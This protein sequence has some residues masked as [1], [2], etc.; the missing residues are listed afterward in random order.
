MTKSLALNLLKLDS[1]ETITMKKHEDMMVFI[2]KIGTEPLNGTSKIVIEISSL[3]ELASTVSQILQIE[4]EKKL[5]I[6]SFSHLPNTLKLLKSASK[7]IK[8]Q[9]KDIKQKMKQQASDLKSDMKKLASVLKEYK[10]RCRSSLLYYL[11]TLDLDIR[12]ILKPLVPSNVLNEQIKCPLINKNASLLSS[13]GQS[14]NNSQNL[15]KEDKNTENKAASHVDLLVTT[16]EKV[17][18]DLINILSEANSQYYDVLNNM[19]SSH[20]PTPLAAP[21]PEYFV[22]ETEESDLPVTSTLIIKEDL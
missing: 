21:L 15:N 4:K 18:K 10:E 7:K 20:P 8:F 6:T 3:E 1:L 16:L 17:A 12:K 13:S 2:E 9:F 22:Y 14:L 19:S 5:L 11:K